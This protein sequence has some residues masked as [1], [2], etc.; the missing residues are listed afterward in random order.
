VFNV[1]AVA[2]ALWSQSKLGGDTYQAADD[3]SIKP[4]QLTVSCAVNAELVE[5]IG[6]LPLDNDL[7]AVA[8]QKMFSALKPIATEAGDY[9]AM[10]YQPFKNFYRGLLF[11][12]IFCRVNALIMEQLER[13]GAA[14]PA[15]GALWILCTRPRLRSRRRLYCRQATVGSEYDQPRHDSY[16][17]RIVAHYEAVNFASVRSSG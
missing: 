13:C 4:H 15:D 9:T 17:R 1:A 2:R 6:N 8:L 10:G 11:T 5:H 16:Q 14:A 3:K 7:L 12:P